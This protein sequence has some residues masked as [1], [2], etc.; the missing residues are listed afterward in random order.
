[1]EQN[2]SKTLRN[3]LIFGATALVTFILGLLASSITE[4]RAE[5]QYVY[6]PQVQI[7]ETEPRN[8]VWGKNFPL[9]YTSW[10]QTKDT[11]FK[12][13]YNGNAM[14]DMLE[15]DPRLVVLWAGYLFSRD[16]NQSRGHYYSIED[17][18]KTLRTGAPKKQKKDQTSTCGQ[19]K[20]RCT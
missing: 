6:K 13:K 18:W 16:Y 9:E 2:K 4:R 20:P 3:W 5:T 14:I 8:D 12:S 15:E 19:Q 1:M 11:S 10:Q 7:N 17:V